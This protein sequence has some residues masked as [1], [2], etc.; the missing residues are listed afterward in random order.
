MEDLFGL[1]GK[2]AVV[3][4]GGVVINMSSMAAFKLLLRDG[5]AGRYGAR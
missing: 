2:V 3:T 5:V 1:K 4:G